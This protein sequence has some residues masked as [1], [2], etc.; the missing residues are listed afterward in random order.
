MWKFLN[1]DVNFLL[2]RNKNE[3][4]DGGDSGG[5][6][7]VNDHRKYRHP[8]PLT[9]DNVQ[10]KRFITEKTIIARTDSYLI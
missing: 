1:I 4:C 3:G 8:W 6:V 10:N 7:K 5:G 2:K 9:M